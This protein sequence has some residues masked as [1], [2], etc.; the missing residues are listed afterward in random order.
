MRLSSWFRVLAMAALAATPASGAAPSQAL[1][2]G[3]TEQV[4]VARVRW[5]IRMRESRPGACA[6]LQAVD[7]QVSED[8]EPREVTAVEL[9]RQATAHLLLVDVSGSMLRWLPRVRQAA[10]NYMEGLPAGDQVALAIFGEDL[11]LARTLAAGLSPLDARALI[12]EPDELRYTA[13]WE[14]VDG[15]VRY[16]DGLAQRKILILLTDGCDSMSRPENGLQDV[17]ERAARVPGLTILPLVAG[18]GTT[19]G[20][21]P[22]E[23]RRLRPAS[24][25]GPERLARRTGGTVYDLRSMAQVSAAFARIR[26]RLAR[27]GV[28]VYARRES[29]LERYGE[30]DSHWVRVKVRSRRRG[31]KVESAGAKQRLVD[32][33]EVAHAEPM[34]I[35]AREGDSIGL[36]VRDLVRDRGSL[37]A[38]PGRFIVYLDRNP[39]HTVRQVRIL[40][41]DLSDIRKPSASFAERAARGMDLALQRSGENKPLEG[42]FMHG[43]TFL[44]NREGLAAALLE[45]PEYG[46][47]A[48]RRVAEERLKNLARSGEQDGAPVLQEQAARSMQSLLEAS[49]DAAAAAPF[50]SA[51]LADVQALD[52]ARELD[53]RWSR[54]MLR[55][56]RPD[57]RRQLR[58]EVDAAWA[59]LRRV[60]GPPTEVRIRTLLVP[61]Y[62]PVLRVVGFVR[63]HLP[64]TRKGQPPLGMLPMKPPALELTTRLSRLG[65]VGESAY[66]QGVRTVAYRRPDRHE[67]QVFGS[68]I[69]PT[70]ASAEESWVVDM[71]THWQRAGSVEGTDSVEIQMR[72]FMDLAG[73]WTCV[74]LTGVEAAAE[75]S[76]ISWLQDTLRRARMSCPAE[77]FSRSEYLPQPR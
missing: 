49:V 21:G 33:V 29:D 17:V 60:F 32:E 31:C 66:L 59:D 65:E 25:S 30:R 50:L 14:A 75:E 2:F 45:H 73:G 37:Y 1:R 67:R 18:F 39:V 15:A 64:Q 57:I 61:A 47:W 74:A 16:L 13:L 12:P 23:G 5:P 43:G 10:E 19:C 11:F 76:K 55:E 38:A 28:V 41:P 71:G 35:V 8:G 34:K 69:A 7:I 70:A 6:G 48:R 42:V 68:W 72:A 20:P 54:K 36:E 52:V 24:R 40:L 4:A 56:T 22:Y 3:L 51:W 53:R 77:L 62:D 26:R 63:I 46:E 58:A 44:E 9:E 27:E